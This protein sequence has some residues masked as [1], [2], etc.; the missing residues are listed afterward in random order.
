MIIQLMMM[1]IANTDYGFV[2]S[3]VHFV[4]IEDIVF[5]KIS[6]FNIDY[7]NFNGPNEMA[8]SIK[9][10][11]AQFYY[12]LRLVAIAFSLLTLIYV[13]IRM[14]L[15][16]TSEGKAKYKK[17]FIGWVESMILLFVLQYIIAIILKLGNVAVDMVAQLKDTNL[18]NV[19]FEQKILK[20][21]TNLLFLEN[22]WNHAVYSLIFWILVYVQ[23]KFFLSYAKRFITVGFLVMIA[24]LIT[25]IYPIDKA[26]DGKTQV[27]N[28]WLLE[29]SMNVFIQP[30]HAII[31]ILFMYLAGE[32]AKT[33][34]L[35]AVL[36]LLALTKVEKIVFQLFHIGGRSVHMASEERKKG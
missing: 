14:A 24:P 31:Y 22:G 6:L 21:V 33:S 12:V 1:L 10:S 28:H 23:T 36:F 17:M 19:S 35:V 11:V 7:F 32:I 4:T 9:E 27:F 3:S 18:E 25:V 30:I 8:N 13:G 2:L 15:S 5:N 29:L 26:N 34:I 16:L 20:E